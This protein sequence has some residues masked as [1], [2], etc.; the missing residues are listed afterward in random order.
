MSESEAVL[1]AY[2]DVAGDSQRSIQ[3]YAR[4]VASVREFNRDPFRWHILPIEIVAVLDRVKAL[5]V[6]RYFSPSMLRVIGLY[7]FEGGGTVPDQAELARLV[8]AAQAFETSVTSAGVEARF[9]ETGTLR[10]PPNP[11]SSSFAPPAVGLDLS[12]AAKG[13][14]LD[15]A[16]RVLQDA[17]KRGALDGALISAG[18]TTLVAGEKP[19]ADGAEPW[20]VGIE[21]PRKPDEVIGDRRVRAEGGQRSDAGSPLP[22]GTVSTSGDYQQSFV[23]DGVRYHHILDPATGKPARGMR[24]LTVVGAK[25]RRR[26]RHP[27]DGSLRDGDRGRRGVRP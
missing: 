25:T 8:R 6:E 17:A 2:P 19:V 20:R 5:G 18:S 22:L 23:R 9:G 21:D 4:K 16:W 7:D 15:A 10:A 27:V 13:A 1:S 26:F 24:S 14:A 11:P 12:G 3:A